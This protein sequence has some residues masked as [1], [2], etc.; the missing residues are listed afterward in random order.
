MDPQNKEKE[1][2]K[3]ESKCDKC[4]GGRWGKCGDKHSCGCGHSF[5]YHGL[6]WLFAIIIIVIVFS[7]GIKVGELKGLVERS[8]G[9]HHSM[10]SQSMMS[11]GEYGARNY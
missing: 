10:Y 7:V 5:V 9:Y 6:R 11:G 3:D 8:G 2:C 1:M 4:S